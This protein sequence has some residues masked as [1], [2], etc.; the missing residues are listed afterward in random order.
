MT[1]LSVDL[2]EKQIKQLNDLRARQAASQR[3]H[4]EYDRAFRSDC[5][6]MHLTS[7]WYDICEAYEISSN[8]EENELLNHICSSKQIEYFNKTKN[9]LFY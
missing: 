5:E 1:R 3:A 8:D 7:I 9:S 4:E 2:S 6:K